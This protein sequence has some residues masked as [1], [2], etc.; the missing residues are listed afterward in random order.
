MI[1]S[2]KNVSLFSVDCDLKTQE[3]LILEAD[4]LIFFTG[5]EAPW[6]P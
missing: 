3:M 6:I 4:I 5:Q 2:K 1:K